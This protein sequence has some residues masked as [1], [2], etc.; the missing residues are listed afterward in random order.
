MK[1]FNA[2]IDRENKLAITSNKLLQQM[3]VAL[4][5]VQ[6]ELIRVLGTPPLS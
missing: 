4:A 1:R 2:V 5:G 3:R 6:A